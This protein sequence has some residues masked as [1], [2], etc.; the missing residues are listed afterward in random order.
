MVVMIPNDITAH[1][2]THYTIIIAPADGSDGAVKVLLL[3]QA[4]HGRRKQ[5]VDRVKETC[6]RTRDVGL[7]KGREG[8][9]ER[10]LMG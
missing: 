3:G 8:F 9:E 5:L 6:Q 2:V 7:L 10:N 1:D 4:P